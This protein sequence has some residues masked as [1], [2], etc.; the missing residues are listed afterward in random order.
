MYESSTSGDQSPSP[1]V[2]MLGPEEILLEALSG[3]RGLPPEIVAKVCSA[4]KRDQ[5]R[6]EALK[7]ALRE[8]ANA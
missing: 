5:Q 4:A 3:L 1:P 6:V 7:R 2:P 8:S